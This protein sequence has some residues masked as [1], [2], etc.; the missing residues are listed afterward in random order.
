MSVGAICFTTSSGNRGC[1]VVLAFFPSNLF[2]FLE[3][4]F[5]FHTR[6]TPKKFANL[7]P[8]RKGFGREKTRLTPQKSYA[9]YAKESPQSSYA[10]LV[11]PALAVELE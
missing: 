7:T 8:E 4:G 2:F 3:R 9:T 10:F 11:A 6:C 1:W 5:F